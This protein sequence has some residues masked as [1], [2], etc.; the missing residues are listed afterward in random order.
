VV[1]LDGGFDV[2]GGQDICLEDGSGH[3]KV[4]PVV[5][6]REIRRVGI[7]R[8]QVESDQ[9]IGQGHVPEE[10]GREVGAVMSNP[11]MVLGTEVQKW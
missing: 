11:F 9:F 7:R 6:E 8:W 3:Q 10:I 4:G 1:Q 2:E 5:I